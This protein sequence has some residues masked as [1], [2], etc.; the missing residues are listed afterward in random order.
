M[1]LDAHKHKKTSP[2][3]GFIS[4]GILAVHRYMDHWRK[5]PSSFGGSRC[6][7]RAP[8]CAFGMRCMSCSCNGSRSATNFAYS[9]PKFRCN[10]QQAAD[11]RNSLRVFLSKTHANI[12]A[13]A[14]MPNPQLA[15]YQMAE[16]INYILSL[17]HKNKN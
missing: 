14:S 7:S 5:H 10:C 9:R 17:R 16:V 6:F 15:N 1:K 4:C 2:E 13:S 12:A 11:D 8:P 3:Y